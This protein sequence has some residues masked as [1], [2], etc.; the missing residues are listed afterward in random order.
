[1]DGFV[2]TPAESKIRLDTM[3]LTLTDGFGGLFYDRLNYIADIYIFF[4]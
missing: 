4:F 2:K 3:F 1:V